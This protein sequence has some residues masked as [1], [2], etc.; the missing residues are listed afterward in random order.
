[1]PEMHLHGSTRRRPAT[2]PLNGALP[3][4]CLLHKLHPV[5]IGLVSTA[6][7]VA[8]LSRTLLYHTVLGLAVPYYIILIIHNL[9]STLCY[10]P[11]GPKLKRFNFNLQKINTKYSHAHQVLNI[12]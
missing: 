2:I 9:L 1:M 4:P 8:P 11:N 10:P 3:W 12:T 5:S 6:C 7:S